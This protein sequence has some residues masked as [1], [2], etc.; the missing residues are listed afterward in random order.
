MGGILFR[1]ILWDLTKVFFMAL[2]AITGILLLGSIVAEASKMGLEPGQIL[3]AIP[4]LVPSTLPYTI[5]ATTLF[6]ACLV[7]G[8]MA[9]DHELLAIKA[10]GGN[11]ARVLL[12]GVVLGLAMSAATAVLYHRIIPATH[13]MLRSMAF[14]DVEKLMYQQL[15][16]NGQVAYPGT[17]YS[18]F[19]QAVHGKKLIAPVFKRRGPK[20]NIDLVAHA[21]EA[22]LRVDMANKE[23]VL[24]MRFGNATSEDGA[25]AD[26]VERKFP[27][28]LPGFDKNENRR[29]RDMTWQE[30]QERREE[31]EEELDHIRGE[32]EKAG[33]AKGPA[34]AAHLKAKEKPVRQLIQ[35]IDVERLMRPALSLGCLC[36]ILVGCPVAVWFSRGD[37]LG[38]FITVF[39]PIVA[40]YY[41][42]VLCGTDM[43][44]NARF[45]EVALVFG[46]DILVAVAGLCLMRWLVKY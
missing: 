29:P 2:V 21:K 22:E 46:P 45:N 36:F 34:Q 17:P 7:Y 5:P 1:M 33:A 16:S 40:T 26:F 43:A 8:R 12:P 14:N 44:K 27:V 32:A 28:P 39:L 23:L 9:A 37:Y 15:R 4:L 13:H 30:L 24:Y 6:A 41:P 35:A 18:M 10:A 25:R 42:L 31:L 38:S 3:T 20:G 19:V 11:L